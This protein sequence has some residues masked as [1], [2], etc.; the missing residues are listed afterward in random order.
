MK[1]NNFLKINNKAALAPMAG[2]TD[3]SLEKYVLYSAQDISPVK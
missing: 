2:I 3:R 1:S